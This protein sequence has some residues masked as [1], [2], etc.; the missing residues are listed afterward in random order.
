MD[1]VISLDA[2]DRAFVYK[3]AVKKIQEM[4]PDY[5]LRVGFDMDFNELEK[6]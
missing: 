4:Y 1:V 2:K 6:Q 3:E 5:K